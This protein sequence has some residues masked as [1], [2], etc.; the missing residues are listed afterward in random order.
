MK[1]DPLS[2]PLSQSS[3]REHPLLAYL[4]I[5][6]FDHWVKNVFVLPGVVVALAFE[7]VPLSVSLLYR[8]VLGLLS[9]G[10]VASS[11]YVLNEVL[12]S[13]YDA[14]H[15]I[16]RMRPVPS[17][18]VKV[19]YAYVEW[20]LLAA[21]GVAIG[22][23]CGRAF[24]FTM[25]ALWF[26]GCVYNVPPVRSKDLPYIDVLS[27]AVNNPLRLL[28]GFFIVG[29]SAIAPASLLCSYWMVGCYFMAIK[30]F[31]EYRMLDSE[32]LAASYR[33]SFRYY[34]EERLLVAI[35]FYGCAAMLFLGAFIVRYKLELILSFPLVAL[36]MSS[37]LAVSFKHD[38]AAQAPEKLYRES[39]LMLSVTACAA[40]MA[41][42]FFTHLP[43]LHR[44]FAPTAPVDDVP[45]YQRHTD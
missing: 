38:S 8:L 5:A 24:M 16:K 6:R 12:D 19:G 36:V 22:S 17:G 37:Y 21:L 42:L 29:P 39:R 43:F 33:K 27:E 35:T 26:M 31:S 4:Q 7:P 44:L 25:I 32:A 10:L 1:S 23:L 41:L 20:L 34:S 45:A 18:K 9:V 14:L 40:V 28:A 11:N 3:Q 13:P 30:R 15:P 2:S